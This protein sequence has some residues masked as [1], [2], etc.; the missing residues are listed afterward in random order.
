MMRG[1]FRPLFYFEPLAVRLWRAHH[2]LVV[3]SACLEKRLRHK[4]IFPLSKQPSEILMKKPLLIFFWFGLLYSVFGKSVFAQE[5]ASDSADVKIIS[6]SDSRVV[7]EY[8]PVWQTPREITIHNQ[9]FYEYKA[10]ETAVEMARAGLPVIPVKTVPVIIGTS[11]SPVVQVISAATQK[12]EGVRLAPLPKFNLEENAWDYEEGRA[13]STF[14]FSKVAE[15]ASVG[16][17]RGYHVAYINIYPLSYDAQTKVLKKRTRVVVSVSFSSPKKSVV[18][19]MKTTWSNQVVSGAINYDDAKNWQESRDR[20]SRKTSALSESVLRSGRFYKLEVAKEGIYKLDKTYLNSI[21]ISTSAID[22]KKLKVFFNDGEELDPALDAEKID[23]LNESAIYVHGEADG[24][25]DDEDYLLFYA[26]TTSGVKYAVP[27]YPPGESTANDDDARLTHYRNRQAESAYAFLALDGDDGQRISTTNSLTAANPVQAESFQNLVFVENE[28]RN[29]ANSGGDLFD[30]P[31][32]NSDRETTYKVSLP[33]IDKT[34]NINYFFKAVST[35]GYETI[36]IY[37][38]TTLLSSQKTGSK[39]TGYLVGRYVWA[40]AEVAASVVSSEQSNFQITYSPSPISA[41]LYPD[42]LEITYHRDFQAD[43]DV[44]K[45]NSLVSLTNGAT[46]AYELTNF[47]SEP[48]IWEITDINNIQEIEPLSQT[49]SSAKFQAQLSPDTYREFFAFSDAASFNEPASAELLDNQNLHGF[50]SATSSSRNPE[51][52]II[53]ATDYKSDAERLLAHRSSTSIWGSHALSGI[54]V[55]AQQVYNEFSGGKQDFTAIRDFLKFLYDN[56]S[57]LDDAPKYV[58]LFGDGDWDF[59]SIKNDDYE[60]LVTYQSD[61]VLELV[62]DVS[63]ADDF[64]GSVDGDEIPDDMVPDIA[65]GRLTVQSADE[66][67]LAVDRIIAYETEHSQGS[68]RNHVALVADDGLN[69]GA[70][71]GSLFSEDSE[72]VAA[73]LPDY[74]M[75]V[76]IYSAFFPSESV[77]G[78]SRRPEAYEE[79]ISQI[80]LGAL[81]T[82][83]VGHGSPSLWATE[84]IFVASTSISKL[85]NSDRLTIGVAATCD[86]GRMDDPLVQ[87]GAEQMFIASNGGAVAMFSTTRSIYISSGSAYPPILFREIFRR[88]SDGELQRLGDG[89]VAFKALRGGE[90]D[91][92][93]FALIG[94]PALQLAVGKQTVAIDSINGAAL[95]DEA[96]VQIGALSKTTIQGSV[97]DEAGSRLSDF[98]GSVAVVVYDAAEDKGADHFA[99]SEYDEYYEVQ[100][101]KVYKGTATVANGKFQVKFIVP[102][103]IKY[104]SVKTGKINLYAWPESGTPLENASGGTTALT[105]FG[106][107]ESAIDDTEGPVVE[108]FLNDNSFR[109]GGI[110]D[111]NPVFLAELYD[112]SGIN[113]T[114]TTG[115]FMSLVIDSD[116][117]N[118]IMLNDYYE[119]VSESLT[120]GKI[121]YPMHDLSAG[122]HHLAFKV[123]DNYNNSSESELYFTVQSSDALSLA[124]PLNFPNPFSNKTIFMLSHNRTGD[125]I[126]TTIKIYTIAGRLIKTLKQTDYTAPAMI[127]IP[128]DGRD[129]DGSKIANGIYLYK[130][131]MKSLS[132]NFH[133]EALQKLAVAR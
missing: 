101:S 1:V 122:T 111:E 66:A 133:A 17:A 110:T 71:D 56:A 132:G 8:T 113:L 79:I 104:D 89:F 96:P 116:E 61:E 83:Y 91:A 19:T 103:D 46:V 20:S 102:R 112:E 85:T 94:D 50:I 58:L 118:P 107:D 73:V 82:N 65:V 123:W 32:G 34:E 86:F 129:D 49:K 52:I 37:E 130:V 25:F 69:G 80:N 114:Q 55:D 76:K 2:F 54:A 43:D 120:E 47:E 70:T 93:K 14:S 26:K 18:K 57:S 88:N 68:W 22:P 126:Q 40:S 23:D 87:S 24:S 115:K 48:R 16:T 75:P 28:Y 6:S 39:P 84:Q 72:N 7:F 119:A 15:V 125:N 108:M 5:N 109:S 77:V 42:W 41:R 21:G 31:L 4:Y 63:I 98:S 127:Q 99:T 64:F 45:F 3:I 29:F 10:T 90:V 44:L 121:Q 51:Y 128:W 11:Q 100:D 60:K 74:I 117:A 81:F 30:E 78:G 59:R 92:T 27:K 97:R 38:N 67:A 12:V 36:A 131:M 95:S 35:G 62:N 105:F 106:T 9:T 33:G 13:Y 124:E 53:Y